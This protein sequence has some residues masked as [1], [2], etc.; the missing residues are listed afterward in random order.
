[1][2]T[3][4]QKKEII[5]NLEDKLSRQKTVVFAEYAGLEVNKL[6][7]LRKRLREDNID[8]KVARK[9]LINLALKKAGFDNV[10]VKEL[11]GQI[12]MII[13]YESEVLPAKLVYEFAR[14]ND[15]FKILA[16]LVQGQYMDKDALVRI[17][18]LPSRQ[19]LLAQL[20][21]GVAAPISGLLSVMQGNLKSLVYVLNSI[22]DSK[23]EV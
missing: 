19:E 17:A 13:G 20:V 8:Y 21:G 18:K 10:D 23:Q 9:T 6:Q 3:K 15:K 5:K 14:K 11:N 2:I 22:K 12:S 7:T 4:Q 1:M 16:G